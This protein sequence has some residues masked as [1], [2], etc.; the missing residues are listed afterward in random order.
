MIWSTDTSGSPANSGPHLFKPW[1]PLAPGDG[2]AAAR[3]TPAGYGRR[4]ISHFRFGLRRVCV[5]GLLAIIIAGLVGQVLR[6]RSVLSA[7]LMYLPLL[8]AGLAAIALDLSL[9]GRAIPPARFGLAVVGVV[10]CIPPID[11]VWIRPGMAARACRLFSGPASDHRGQMVAFGP[12]KSSS[13]P[14][15]ESL[16]NNDVISEPAVPRRMSTL[17]RRAFPISRAGGRRSGGSA[18]VQKSPGSAE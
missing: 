14:A 17:A 12:V 9:R 3:L 16:V 2:P 1:F 6:D 7:V 10:G 13:E 18:T 5:T 11:H 8:P 4:M 15:T